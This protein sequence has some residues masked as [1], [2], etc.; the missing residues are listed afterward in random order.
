MSTLIKP[1]T[2]SPGATIVAAEHNDNFDTIYD[3]FNG[4]ISNV[5]VAADAAISITKISIGSS[6][7]VYFGSATVDGSWKMYRS[8]NDLLFA[9]RESSVWVDKG[10]YI[11]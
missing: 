3:D 9:R 11:A 10:G 8:G 5:N 2:F 6:D 7:V 1:Y 4:S